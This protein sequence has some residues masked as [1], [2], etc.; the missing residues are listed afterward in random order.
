MYLKSLEL[1]GFKSFP[2]KIRLYFDKGL[3]AVVG[4]NGSGKS[5][6]GDSVRWVLGEQSTKTLRGN[7]MEDVIFSGT[8]GRKPMGFAM[9]TLIIDNTENRLDG[10]GEEVSISRKLY[11]SGDSEFRING[12]AVR[13][14]DIHELF[15]DTGLGRDGYSIIGQGRIA[16]IV[17]AKSTERREIF[18]EAAGISRFR[19]KKAEAERQL[20]L[21]QEKMERVQDIFQE[22]E[23]R[24]EPLKIQA[25]K[26]EN[27]LVLAEQEKQLEVSVWVQ[28]LEDLQKNLLFL[29]EKCLATRS[30]YEQTEREMLQEEE[31]IQQGYLRMQEFSVQAEESHAQMKQF[32]KENAEIQAE[33]AVLK[34]DILHHQ[35]AMH[36]ADSRHEEDLQEIHARTESLQQAEMFMQ[37]MQKLFTETEKQL[38]D[39]QEQFAKAEKNFQQG[40]VDF[41]QADDVLHQQYLEKNTLQF[42]IRS[43]EEKLQTLSQELNNRKEHI[44]HAEQAL[45]QA[46]QQ[47]QKSQLQLEQ[48]KQELQEQEHLFNT[49][50]TEVQQLH[51]EKLQ[52]EEQFRQT[53]FQLREK[54]QRHRI[55][56]DLENQ[57]EGFSGSVKAI[58]RAVQQ[59]Q[60]NHIYGSV[61]QLIQVEQAYGIAVETALGASVQHMIVEN[62]QA[63]KEGI[64]FLQ[65][66]HAGRATFLPLTTIKGR[67][68]PAQDLQE[69]SKLEGFIA[70]ASDL[71][72]CEQRYRQ[73]A[74]NLLGRII[75]A[76]HLDHATEI[77]K[78]SHYRYRIVTSDGQV[79]NAGGSFTGGS[80]QKTGGMLTRKTE[81]HSL[82]EEIGKFAL[83][84]SQAEQFAR[85]SAE[86]FSQK[87]NA[88]QDITQ[89][90]EQLRKK[91]LH[92]QTQ[93][94]KDFFPIEQYQKQLAEDT[95]K[96]QLLQEQSAQAEKFLQESKQ[97]YEQKISEIEQ[98]ENFFSGAESQKLRL[99]TEQQNA[100]EQCNALKIRLAQ[101]EKDK[102]SSEQAFQQKQQ[103]LQLLQERERKFL[104]EQQAHQEQILSKTKQIQEKETL[105]AE[106]EQKI[107]SSEQQAKSASRQ[108]DLENIQ[109]RQL[110]T[111]L[112]T[113]HVEKEKLSAELSRVTERQN[114]VQT[115]FDEIISNLLEIY[116]LT[117]SEAQAFAKPIEHLAEAKKQLSGI[118]QKIR[119]LGAVNTDSIAEYAEVSQRYHFYAHEIEDVRKAKQ[120]LEKMIQHLT[121]EMSRIFHEN[122]QL[123]NQNFQKIFQDLFG[124][125]RAELTL[126]EPEQI[127]TSGIEINVAPPG[128][129]IKNL[130]SLSGGEQAF[131]A[132]AI[133]FAILQ[134]RPAPFCILDEIDAALDEANVRRY[135]QYLK[136]FTKNTQFVLVT[137]RRSAM[138]EAEILY[139]VTMQ[140]D[141]ISRLLKLEQ[142]EDLP[143]ESTNE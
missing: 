5:N 1:Q 86:H 122:F 99:F 28:H 96:I 26:A 14:K 84:C 50:Q 58:M 120:E 17:S 59:K 23:N 53:G 20:A 43:A 111:G 79:I 132:I 75:I 102:L 19:Y 112:T 71:V 45:C 66:S 103:E 115:E 143:E 80:V 100:A 134:L 67:Y 48:L 57:L 91:F 73:I 110:Q 9:V 76:D 60:L 65:N 109:I 133:Y 106:T 32:Q 107:S 39:A 6:I 15:M 54:K 44:H 30:E 2:D 56:T 140:E 55:L 74:E 4:P 101:V 126:T 124:G 63:A 136:Q 123:I 10:Y 41:H 87:E 52:A 92:Q 42:T 142:P 113:L 16:E 36:Y 93:T 34:N 68:L 40:E 129:V 108:H 31:K 81:L 77:A 29:Q 72:T 98:A 89:K 131:V 114:S 49:L 135:A 61:A 35:E 139:G 22:L 46:E 64:R 51:Q 125:G 105:Y 90:T 95:E 83:Q 88:L 127:L 33:I 119:S 25:E 37:D 69:I 38:A 12:K 78:M 11:R 70:V 121:S 8:V 138:E 85:Q 7:K 82:Q 27:Y 128:K 94:Q 47:Y 117:R 118:K 97:H 137:H 21:A 62:E 13:L 18:E 141:G 130:I 24:L 104:S 116:E 3:T